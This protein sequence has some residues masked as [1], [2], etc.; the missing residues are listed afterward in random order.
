MTDRATRA[1]ETAAKMAAEIARLEDELRERRERLLAAK[2][3]T[4]ARPPRGRLAAGWFATWERHIMP[5]ARAEGRLA[6][7]LRRLPAAKERAEDAAV[8]AR[9]AAA[10]R[11]RAQQTV[12][13]LTRQLDELKAH[14]A[15]VNQRWRK[16][17]AAE[18]RRLSKL[19]AK[20]A[21]RQAAPADDEAPAFD[22]TK[23]WDDILP[24]PIAQPQAHEVSTVAP[25]RPGLLPGEF[26]LLDPARTSLLD[27]DP[28]PPRWTARHVGARLIE[29]HQI[30]RRIPVV[31]APKGMA[32]AW[33]AFQ[34]PA[35]REDDLP[36]GEVP[37]RPLRGATPD[38]LARMDEALTWPI[39]ILTDDPSLMI[40]DLSRWAER[41]ADPDDNNPP[42]DALTKIAN[43]LNAR[44]SPVR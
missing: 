2:A 43:A 26:R 7:L 18:A 31:I 27:A 15:A 23:G 30:L 37:T 42:V 36:D 24:P 10:K 21:Q 19:K 16:E 4:L 8:A 29:A 14:A 22:P 28:L 41:A 11:L 12:A 40:G 35:L 32:T 44:G 17:R 20:I 3:K 25:P 9:Q 33:P 34:K 38:Q 39:E 5:I 1:A 6:R 13:A